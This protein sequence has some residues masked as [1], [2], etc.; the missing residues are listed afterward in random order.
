ML[1]IPWGCIVMKPSP[2]LAA[3]LGLRPLSASGTD[4][5]QGTDQGRGLETRPVLLMTSSRQARSKY[6]VKEIHRH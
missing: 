6:V 2:D 5:V 3:L 4:A 1:G